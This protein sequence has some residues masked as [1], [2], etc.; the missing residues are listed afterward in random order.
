MLDHIGRFTAIS[1]VSVLVLGFLCYAAG[2]RINTTR[3]IPLGLYWITDEPVT[4]DAYVIFC[5]P[6]SSLFDEAKDRGY[7]SA[8]FCPGEYGFMMK[9]VMAAEHDCVVVGK[10]GITINKILLPSSALLETDKAGRAMPRYQS[11]IYTLRNSELLLMSDS[12]TSFDS[13]YFGP[14]QL[15]QIKG[16]I[17][18]V[19]TW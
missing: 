4:K 2:A 9:R 10:D 12:S 11:R 8:G 6:Q 5:P 3:S 1:G 13:R 17:H 19:F 15:S 16:V 14:I 18:P 7:I